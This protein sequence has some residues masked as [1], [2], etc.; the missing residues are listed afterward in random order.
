MEHASLGHIHTVPCGMWGDGNNPPNST[1]TRLYNRQCECGTKLPPFYSIGILAGVKPWQRNT[2][3]NES[4]LLGM[5]L[6]VKAQGKGLDTWCLLC[7][8]LYW[9]SAFAEKSLR[10]L[11]GKLTM[12]QQY[13]LPNHVYSSVSRSL[14]FRISYY[15][16][17]F[18]NCEIASGVLGQILDVLLQ[19]IHW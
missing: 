10:V 6:S 1:W 8:L 11:A 2:K 5:W 17:L 18:S 14:A 9:Q 15:G 3:E 4:L 19:G 7:C 16:P 12:S 13:V